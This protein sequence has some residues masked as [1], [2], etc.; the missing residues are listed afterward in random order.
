MVKLVFGEA[1]V[2]NMTIGKVEQFIES[3]VKPI[4]SPN[5][6][7]AAAAVNSPGE[8]CPQ[9][10]FVHR[11]PLWYLVRARCCNSISPLL[12]KINTLNA[13]CKNRFTMGFYFFHGAHLFI[14]FVH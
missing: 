12:L 6:R 5:L 2:E 3:V 11:P 4:S 7:A 13:R 10:A 1:I 9:Q 8:G 14:L